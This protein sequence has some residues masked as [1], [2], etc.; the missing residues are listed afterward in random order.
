MIGSTK[1]GNPFAGVPVISGPTA[2]GKSNLALRLAEELNG[3]II[4]VDSMTLYRD[5]NIGT[6]KPT[7]EE[8]ARVPHHL[9]D[10]LD[11]SESAHVAWWLE[12]A[13]RVLAEIRSRGRLPIFVGGTPMYL[14]AMIHGLFDSPP[15]D[16]QIR[17]QLEEQAAQLGNE[18]FHA[19]LKEVDPIT[20]SRLHPNDVRRVV[21]ALEV[22]RLSGKPLSAWQTQG[23]FDESQPAAD[24][25]PKIWVID[26]PR[27]EL[28]QRINQRVEAMWQ[29]G[30]VEEVRQLLQREKPPSKEALQALGY[31]EIIAF[32]KGEK[33]FTQTIEEISAH[34]RQ[35]AKRQMTWFRGLKVCEFVPAKTSYEQ[36]VEKIVEFTSASS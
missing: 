3:E 5:M 34:T 16:V 33:N 24:Q 31:S 1:K 26:W 9:I 15:V 23:W 11:P 7:R 35:F 30:W 12:Q 27:Q 13:Q 36:W 6:A 4:S 18:A 32:L 22:Y 10:V 21:R 29:A 2:S 25:I 19:Q 28:H 17:Q 14:K 20:A 8:Q